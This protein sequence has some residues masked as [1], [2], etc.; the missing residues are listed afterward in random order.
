VAEAAAIL[1]AELEAAGVP[2]PSIGGGST[3][4]AMASLIWL[5]AMLARSAIAWPNRRCR[6]RPVLQGGEGQRRVL[7]A[8]G[9]AEAEDHRAVA[10]ARLAG[11]VR[12][13]LLD[14]LHGAVRLAPGGS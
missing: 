13:D 12:F 14:H 7:P 6:V 1:Q 11:V 9:E 10:D 5:R 2:R 8:T 4:N 3:A